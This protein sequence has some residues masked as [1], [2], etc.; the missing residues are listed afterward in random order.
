MAA[1]NAPKIDNLVIQSEGGAEGG[2]EVW[3]ASVGWLPGTASVGWLDTA[4]NIFLFSGCSLIQKTNNQQ[5]TES[6][7]NDCNYDDD[8]IIINSNFYFWS[9][10]V[11]THQRVISGWFLDDFSVIFGWFWDVFSSIFVWF[12]V[13][14]WIIIIIII[15][16]IITPTCG[17][18]YL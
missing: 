9:R 12:L 5:K 11:M 6:W 10:G 13:D 16:I 1:P 7:N 15:I 17:Y 3:T 4:M 2:A 8:N 18:L 14:F